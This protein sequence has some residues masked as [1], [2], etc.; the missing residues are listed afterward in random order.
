MQPNICLLFRQ[1]DLSVIYVLNQGFTQKWD[2]VLEAGAGWVL[3]SAWFPM[4]TDEFKSVRRP[5]PATE[6]TPRLSFDLSD[7][8]AR[9][10]ASAIFQIANR[11]QKKRSNRRCYIQIY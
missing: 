11:A 5:F 7:K 1:P 10:L 3:N 6:F 9:C 8:E 4:Y 2:P